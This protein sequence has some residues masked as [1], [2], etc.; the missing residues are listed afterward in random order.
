MLYNQ[1]Y[2]GRRR[3]RRYKKTSFYHCAKTAKDYAMLA[4]NG[5]KY[6]KG[7]VNS[8][9]NSVDSSDSP[10]GPSTSESV[11]HLTAIAQGDAQSQRTGNSILVK[12]VYIRGI[13]EIHASASSTFLR[14]LLVKDNQQVSNTS[15]TADDILQNVQIESPYD[16]TTNQGRF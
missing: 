5:V 7:L 12:S 1:R 3:R 15:P 2:R 4:Y 13:W 8:E 14:F 16:R 11:T 9:L 6:L 10:T